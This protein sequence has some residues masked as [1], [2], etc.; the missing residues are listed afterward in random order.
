MFKII[1]GTFTALKIFYFLGGGGG[2][3]FSY[4]TFRFD[5]RINRQDTF[6]KSDCRRDSLL[7]S[8]DKLSLQIWPLNLSNIY[9]FDV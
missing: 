8:S 4:Y 7:L 3:D 1:L 5:S 6:L 2:E 9:M